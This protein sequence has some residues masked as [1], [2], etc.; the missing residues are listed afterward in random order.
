MIKLC[1]LG[2]QGR[3]KAPQLVIRIVSTREGKGHP[4]EGDMQRLIIY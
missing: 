1:E 4:Q 2:T 3:K